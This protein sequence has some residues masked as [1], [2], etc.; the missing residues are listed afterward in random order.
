MKNILI[1]I[2]GIILFI[3]LCLSNMG[4]FGETAQ[5]VTYVLVGVCGIIYWFRSMKSIKYWAD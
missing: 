3:F 4:V 5:V 2:L 1:I